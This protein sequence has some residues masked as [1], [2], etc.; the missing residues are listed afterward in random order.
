[1]P[2][3]TVTYVVAALA[4]LDAADRVERHAG[5]RDERAARL[6]DQLRRRAGPA[7]ATRARSSP[8][9]PPTNSA[10]V[11]DGSSSTCRTPSP[12]PRSTMRGVQPS[13]ARRRAA[14]PRDP[15]DRH[16]RRAEVHELRA[17]VHVQ[18]LALAAARRI[19]STASS[20]GSPNF[21]PWCAVLTASC[22][23]ASIPGVTRIRQRVAADRARALELVERVEHDQRAHARPRARSS[24]SSL[25][26]PWMTS[27]SPGM[28]A[29]SANSSSPTVETSAPRP[30]SA[31]SRST[32][33]DGNAFVP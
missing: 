33:T 25:L 9:S 14:K 32:A 3:S 22:V 27:R 1:M 15:V 30:S 23:S 20:G 6:E 19:A 8:T 17:D 28:P 4:L 2:P 12:P 18:P 5:A 21:E 24:S 10:I 13:S 16:Q 7:A 11:N 29:R 26:L 31:S